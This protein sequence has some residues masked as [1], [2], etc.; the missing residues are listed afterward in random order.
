MRTGNGWKL[1]GS[2]PFEKL[3]GTKKWSENITRYSNVFF[4]SK[5]ILLCGWSLCSDES[6]F[7]FHIRSIIPDNACVFAEQWHGLNSLT[8]FTKNTYSTHTQFFSSSNLLFEW[9]FS[10]FLTSFF[11]PFIR[12]YKQNSSSPSKTVHFVRFVF[13]CCYWPIEFP[14][15]WLVL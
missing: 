3:K 11:P 8:I 5:E 13:S 1:V 14:F 6:F 12:T 9:L 7:P 10:L 4:F 15:K 2:Q